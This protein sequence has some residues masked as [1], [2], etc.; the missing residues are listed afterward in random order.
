MLTPE[1][2]QGTL[3]PDGTLELD[4]K[5]KLPPCRVQVTVQPAPV[6]STGPRGLVEVMDEIRQGQIARGYHGRTVQEMQAEE[7]ARRD[8]DEE[9]D[10]R[11]QT[12]GGT[13]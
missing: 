12:L 2:I 1:V 11:C 9:D 8:H 7:T 10:R 6:S 5:P 4:D 3:K 13:L